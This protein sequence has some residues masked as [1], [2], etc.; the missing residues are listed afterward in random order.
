MQAYNKY[1]DAAARAQKV[2]EARKALSDPYGPDTLY[3][4]NCP[5]SALDMHIHTHLCCLRGD[6]VLT[7]DVS[8]ELV[9]KVRKIVRQNDAHLRMGGIVSNLPKEENIIGFLRKTWSER[10]QFR[11][12]VNDLLVFSRDYD[13]DLTRNEFYDAIQRSTID[14]NKIEV[15]KIS[16]WVEEWAREKNQ[17]GKHF[18]DALRIWVSGKESD[19]WKDRVENLRT[20]M[21]RRSRPY[22][23]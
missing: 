16:E 4:H 6:G 15:E 22:L 10:E 19:E 12:I 7:E 20:K 13:V 11:Y 5:D 9:E 17:E 1:D 23:E 14:T 3:V 18:A 2:Y 21:A 8:K